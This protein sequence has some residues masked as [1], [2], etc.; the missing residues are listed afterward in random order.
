MPAGLSRPDPQEIAEAI[1]IT[2][3]GNGTFPFAIQLD[4][5]SLKAETG[6]DIDVLYDHYFS[7]FGVFSAGLLL[8]ISPQPDR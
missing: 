7:T 3:S 2:T 1:D 5:P 4:N 6:D 8:Q